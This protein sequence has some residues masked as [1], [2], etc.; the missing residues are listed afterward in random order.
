MDNVSLTS[1]EA[2]VS[3]SVESG[4]YEEDTKVLWTSRF[5]LAYILETSISGWWPHTASPVKG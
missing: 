2:R 1:S 3:L 5:I 4:L